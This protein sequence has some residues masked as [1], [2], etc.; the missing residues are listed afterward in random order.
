MH[1]LYLMLSAD[2][3]N[4]TLGFLVNFCLHQ[5]DL[6]LYLVHLVAHLPVIALLLQ[7]CRILQRLLWNHVRENV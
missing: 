5:F 2:E 6:L 4:L 1:L 3:F 7:F